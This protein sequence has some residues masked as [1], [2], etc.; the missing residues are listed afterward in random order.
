[1]LVRVDGVDGERLS[2]RGGRVNCRRFRDLTRAS[3][4]AEST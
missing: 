2:D 1:M 3:T 4:A